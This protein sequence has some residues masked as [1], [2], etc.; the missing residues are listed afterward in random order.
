MCDRCRGAGRHYRPDTDFPRPDFE[1]SIQ[2]KLGGITVESINIIER[3]AKGAFPDEL[4][5]SGRGISVNVTRCD[6]IREVDKAAAERE[7]LQQAKNF[8]CGE[9]GEGMLPQVVLASVAAKAKPPAP[10]RKKAA[11]KAKAKPTKAKT[12]RRSRT[13]K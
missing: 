7:A 11:T 4:Y 8:A 10:P 3:K 1:A 12:T 13:K 2:D 6:D 9:P 5:H